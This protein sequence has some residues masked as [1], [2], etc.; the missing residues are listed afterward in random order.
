MGLHFPRFLEK[1]HHFGQ[2]KIGGFVFSKGNI[3]LPF[4]IVSHQ[5]VEGM[6]VEIHKKYR[7]AARILTGIEFLAKFQIAFFRIGFRGKQGLARLN[8]IF[9]L[10]LDMVIEVNKIGVRV[11]DERFGEADVQID[12]AGAGKRLYKAG[13]CGK[14]P[15]NPV[16]NAILATSP[17]QEWFS[18]PGCLRG[19]SELCQ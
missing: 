16:Q 9:S 17:F 19:F 18:R 6:A 7:A 15:Q 11:A 8:K 10:P 2:G 3:E 4:G 14:F 13:T 1:I 12:G 5:T